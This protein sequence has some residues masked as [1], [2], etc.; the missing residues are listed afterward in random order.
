[1]SRLQTVPW[2]IALALSFVGCRMP[3]IPNPYVRIP[4]ISTPPP[5][6][7]AHLKDGSG[8][9]VGTAVFLQQGSEVR[10]LLDVSGL[11]PGDKAVHIHEVGQCDPSSF[12]SAQGHFNPTGTQ[13]GTAN[14]RGPHAGDL[15]NI[16]VDPDGRGHLEV[17]TKR[18][19]LEKGPTS[20]F[21]ADGSALVLHANADDMRTDPAGNSGAR[22]ACGVIV[23]GS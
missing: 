9:I 14:P 4:L 20:L 19:T 12:D 3:Y 5:S 7:A 17:S 15:P 18:V 10:L 2:L 21:D 11:P 13:H 1:M 8:R 22:L 6:A 23:P 16:T